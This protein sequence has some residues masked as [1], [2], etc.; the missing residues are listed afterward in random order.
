[1]SRLDLHTIKLKFFAIVKTKKHL[2]LQS[3]GGGHPLFID[4]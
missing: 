4:V 2:H 3:A 1:M